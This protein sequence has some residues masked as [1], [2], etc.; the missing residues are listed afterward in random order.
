MPNRYKLLLPQTVYQKMVAHAL[1]ERPNEC[2]GLL[3]GVPGTAVVRAVRHFSL[4]NEHETPTIEYRSKP[5]CMFAATKTMRSDGL[6]EVAVYHS[7]PTSPPVPSRKDVAR[8]YSDWVMNLIISLESG[9]PEVRA[10]WLLDAGF[11]PA[12]WDLAD[13]D[14]ASNR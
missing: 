10:W 11:E 7:H 4:I 9:Q 3:A 14:D 5:E 6:Q 2:C 1:A 12:E 8:S 13:D